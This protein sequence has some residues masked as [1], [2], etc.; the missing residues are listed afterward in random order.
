MSRSV[1]IIS[2]SIMSFQ[3]LRGDAY[4]VPSCEMGS[5]MDRL[6]RED[7]RSADDDRR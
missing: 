6:V 3:A 7:D 1:E 5:L 2:A 4:S